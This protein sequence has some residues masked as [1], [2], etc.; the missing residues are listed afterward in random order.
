M[1]KRPVMSQIPALG[2]IDRTQGHLGKQLVDALRDAI[3]KGHLAVGERLPSTRTLAETL[4]LSRGTV[5]DAFEQLIAEGCLEART[6]SGTQVAAALHDLMPHV[7]PSSMTKPTSPIPIPESAQRYAAVLNKLNPLP[8]APFAIAVPEGEVAMDEHWR[9]LSNRI[10]GSQSAALTGYSDPSGLLSLRESIAEYLRKSRAVLCKPENIV[11]TEGAQQGLYLASKVLLSNGDSVLA[12]DPAYPGLIS[13]L[14]DLNVQL[15]RI[16]VDDQGFN[17]AKAIEV[18]ANAKAVFVTPSHQ[19]PIGMPLSMSRRLTLVEWARKYNSWIVE[20]DYDSELRYAGYPFPSMQGL[21][22][23]RV[24]YL[25]T[26][27]KVLAP[28]LRLGYMVVPDSLVASFIGARAL[29]GRGSPSTE[30]HVIAAYMSEGYFDAHIRRIRSVYGERR[31][32]LIGAL[33][34]EAPELKV[35]PADQGMHIV[36]WLPEGIDDIQ[37]AEAARLA[38]IAVRAISPMCSAN[39]KLSGLMMGFGGFS[40]D[41]LKAAARKLK[42]VLKQFNNAA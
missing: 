1:P 40:Q 42:K 12:E 15:H 34:K 3:S 16:P 36:A 38:G 26:F 8:S 29:M 18:S 11:I 30:Q 20:D 24:I 37:I 31:E 6:G 10:R 21:D 17:V 7:L 2:A 5:S 13:I 25:G 4:G 39:L 28:S 19:Y 22:S 35:Q 23:E 32:V 27:S 9:K 33:E 14:E 41:Q